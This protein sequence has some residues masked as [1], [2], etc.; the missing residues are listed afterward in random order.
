MNVVCFDAKEPMIVSIIS[1]RS[2]LVYFC[3][4]MLGQFL[5]SHIFTIRILICNFFT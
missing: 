1:V 5:G 4:F 2:T 3:A